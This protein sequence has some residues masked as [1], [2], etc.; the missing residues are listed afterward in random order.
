MM[1]KKTI[2]LVR[3]SAG[4]G[5]LIGNTLLDKGD[6]QLRL[7]IRPGSRDGAAGFEQWGAQIVEDGIGPEAGGALVAL[8][9]GA[10][11]VISAVQSGPDVIIDGQ[12]Q[13]LSAARDAGVK[14]HP[15]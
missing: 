4:L 6:V 9:Q 11:T 8:C 15:V 12:T 1:S 5:T 10:S 14:C 3:G 7:L 2:A 13:L